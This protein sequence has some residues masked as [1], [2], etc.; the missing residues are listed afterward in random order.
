MPD[1][2][3]YET[4][5]SPKEEIDFQNWL[6]KNRKEGKISVGDYNFYKKNGYGYDYD[7]RAAFKAGL[8]PEINQEDKQWHWSDYGKKPNQPTFSNESI[9]Y[10]QSAA[11]GVGGHWD[12]E[13]YI[14]NPS[15][16][17]PV[18]PTGMAYMVSKIKSKRK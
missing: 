11:P 4:K 15:I 7:F 1:P 3:K 17:A 18:P 10:P 9:Y 14:K 13:Q 12:G 5:L 2:S 6:D 16:G 8:K